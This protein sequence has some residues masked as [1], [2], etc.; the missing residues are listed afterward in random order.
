MKLFIALL[1][2]AAAWP[3]R[4]QELLGLVAGWKMDN[5]C[6]LSDILN[7]AP[8]NG[9]MVDVSSVANRENVPQS[10]LAFNQNTSYITFGAVEKLKI[11]GDKSISFW[12]K[13]TLTGSTRTGS[14]FT[15]GDAINIRYTEQSSQASLNIIFGNTSFLQPV[16]TANQWQLVTIT[17]EKDFNST[18]SKVI[19]YVD[20][21]LVS[22]ALQNKSSHDFDKTIALIGPINQNTLTNGFRG[23]LDDLKIFDRVLTSAEVQNLALPVTLEYFKAKKMQR[24]VQLTWK[25]SVEDNVSHFQVERSE[26]GLHFNNMLRVEAGKY[27]YSV[28]DN[29]FKTGVTWYRL[30]IYDRD[31]KSNISNAI[32]ISAADAADGEVSVYPNP[33]VNKI[34]LIGNSTYSNVVILNSSGKRINA[35]IVSN[36]IDIGNLPS[37]LYYVTCSDGER[38]LS[39]KFIKQ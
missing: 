39:S 31:G 24:S 20:G 14:I 34:Y 1:F 25:S 32:R 17:F 7:D 28:L 3:C 5:T 19:Y 35:R 18:K 38:R 15:Y 29:A 11:A 30:K 12:V 9:V 2:I 23:S 6:E 21:V 13:P 33:A 8:V 4:A 36:F 16:L 22:Q 37:G 27:M 10:A 26:D